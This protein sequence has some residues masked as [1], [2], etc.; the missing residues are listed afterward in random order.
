MIPTTP[1]FHP[2]ELLDRATYAKLG[3]A[4]MRYF[5][6][7]II[8]ALDWI[9]ASYPTTGK[10]KI[11]VNDW[12]WGGK[13]EWSGLRLPGSPFYSTYSGHS[14]GAAIDFVPEGITPA[15][16]RSWILKQHANAEAQKFSIASCPILGVRRME[17]DTPTWVHIDCLEHNSPGI[18]MVNP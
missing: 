11:T 3:D 10:R 7:E 13:R 18:W 6:P 5:R 4:G 17:L 16:M 14:W 9:W 2:K 1:N 12:A 15:E 8:R